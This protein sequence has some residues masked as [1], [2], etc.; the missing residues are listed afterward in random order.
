MSFGQQRLWVLEQIMPGSSV[1]NVPIAFRLTG[2]LNIDALAQSLQAVVDRHEVLRTIFVEQEGEGV[3]L[4]LPTMEL[5][6]EVYDVQGSA[7]AEADMKQYIEAK[8]EMPFALHEAPLVRAYLVKVSAVESVL[9]LNM[10]HIISDGWSVGV[11]LKELTALYS[12]AVAGEP[13]PLA[14]LGI[15]Y[16]DYAR[17]QK[18]A[19]SDT[20]L[21]EQL[22]YWKQQLQG[23]SSSLPLPY[24]RPRPQVQ[25][26]SGGQLKFDLTPELAKSL[27]QLS[28]QEGATLFMT[29]LAAFQT[30][31]HR[32][33]GESQISIGTPVAGRTRRETEELIGF[34]VNTLVMRTDLSGEPTFVELVKR[35]RETAL[36]AYAHQD[37]PFEKLVEELQPQ[38][39]TSHSPFFQVMFQV[40]N[41]P[42]SGLH[43]PGVEGRD[44]DFEIN[45]SK[46]DL[47]LALA[48]ED[49]KL[50]GMM[51]YNTDLFDES[52]IARMIGHYVTLL[53]AVSAEPETKI[54]ELP[55][56][57]Q[58][59]QTQ[60][61]QEWNET[62]AG[63]PAEQCVHHLFEA[64][65]QKT[66][67]A[68]AISFEGNSWTYREVN[69]RANV[70]ARHLQALGV[71]PETLVAVFMERT[72]RLII[73]LLA[74]WKAGGAYVP[75]DP[76]H[77]QDRITMI[78]DDSEATLVLTEEHLQTLVP[79]T[80]AQ[81]VCIEHLQADQVPVTDLEHFT[82]GHHLAYVLFTSGSTGR[83]KGVAIEHHSLINLMLTFG[84]KLGS[85]A[86]DAWVAAA[87][88]TFDISGLEFY[89]PLTSGGRIV[90]VSRDTARDGQR[91]LA[92]IT[93]ANATHMVATPSSFYMLLQAGWKDPERFLAVVCGEAIPLELVQRLME[94]GVEVWNGYGP[95]EITVCSSLH[96][97]QPTDEVV[98]IGHPMAN[99]EYYIMDVH[100][101]L[102]PVGVIGELYIGG[103]GL[104]REYWNRP[105]LTEKAFLT[106]TFADG[107]TRRIY[108]TGDLARFLANGTVEILGRMDNQIKLNGY[109]IELGD[110]E[111]HLEQH[112][113]LERGVV[114]VQEPTPGVKRLTAFYTVLPEVSIEAADLRAYMQDKV[115]GY[116]VPAAFV[117]LENFPISESGKVDRR[118]LSQLLVE[119]QRENDYVGPRDRTEY[120]LVKMWERLLG[121]EKIGV[122]DSFF[123]LGGHSLTAVKLSSDVEREFGCRLPLVRLFQESTIE[124]IAA[125][126]REGGES[127]LHPS[128]VE[129]QKGAGTPLFLVHPIGGMAHVYAGLASGLPEQTVY[130]LQARG[131]EEGSGDPIDT[132]EEMA[133]YY[134][135]GV[136]QVQPEGPYRLGGWSFGGVVAYEM[137]RQLQAQGQDVEPLVFFDSYAP[138]NREQWNARSESE[139]AA[140][141]AQDLL[142]IFQDEAAA[143]QEEAHVILERVLTQAQESGQLSISFTRED[144]MRLFTVY[145]AHSHAMGNYEAVAAPQL[146]VILFRASDVPSTQL[147]PAE[148]WRKRV[149]ELTVFEVKGNHY[150]ML[151]PPFVQETSASLNDAI[152]LTLKK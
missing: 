61:V 105:D 85:S 22:S 137:A 112:P 31:L 93:E 148:G 55:I 110:I 145:K 140:D 3:Q 116:M 30:L 60:L 63:Y 19:L 69:E 127:P 142:S 18:E 36:Q 134:L 27:K 28:R 80:D 17:W 76:E 139:V 99:Y 20:V 144:L 98:T 2:D 122:R 74:V 138:E 126:I 77:P 21:S 23:A 79:S 47:T 37:I 43:W 135:E 41:T 34:F 86:Q 107:T 70:L 108:K 143:S 81:I 123:Q 62:Q 14:P 52:T 119:T 78:L 25:T 15:Q 95:T 92:T 73:S 75:L 132:V 97:L 4:I 67:D 149:G 12:A 33:T 72:P 114:V 130:G 152:L 113:A 71:Q 29:L 11:L 46:F 87:T 5:P 49:D 124:Q 121:A 35:V 109:R 91:L 16:S 117:R 129:I 9:L 58:G 57:T 118:A 101:Q 89:V 56:L 82:H 10:H 115:P 88:V 24:D 120:R 100:R 84:E 26:F 147:N 104:A 50:V 39:D 68:V 141:F 102:V 83:P 106:H 151:Q 53:E 13:M 94:A 44:Y 45:L 8:A 65:A 48:E 128:L 1:Y 150:T 38:R 103:V 111:S 32:Y 136:R 125:F 96:P 90:L 133:A 146:Q 131:V 42:S 40:Q 59:E 6:L 64:Q 7:N 51:R 54:V 66:P